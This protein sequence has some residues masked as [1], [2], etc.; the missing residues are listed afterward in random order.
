[1]PLFADQPDN[2]RRVAALG[3]GVVTEPGGLRDAIE[4]V[5]AEAKFGRAAQRLAQEIAWLPPTDA[6]FDGELLR[7]A[8]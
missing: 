2:A 3:A 4:T 1:M 5:L 8:R 7:G 6:A